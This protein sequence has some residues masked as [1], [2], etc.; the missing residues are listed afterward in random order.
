ML[1]V[2]NDDNSLHGNAVDSV[3][4]GLRIIAGECSWEICSWSLNLLQGTELSALQTS[5]NNICLAHHSAHDAS[6]L[7]HFLGLFP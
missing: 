5:S 7:V 3:G 1:L 6:N 2:S 4:E